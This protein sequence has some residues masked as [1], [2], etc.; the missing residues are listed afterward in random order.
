MEANKIFSE[1]AMI[2]KAQ[3]RDVW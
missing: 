3:L 2:R 1:I